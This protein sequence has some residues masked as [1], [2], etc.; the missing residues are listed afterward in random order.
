MN[1]IIVAVSILSLAFFSCSTLD[2]E[3]DFSFTHEVDVV[4]DEN[5]YFSSDLIDLADKV[6]VIDEYGDNIKEI[7]IQKIEVRVTRNDGQPEQEIVEARIEVAKADGSEPIIVSSLT[8]VTLSSLMDSP[9]TLELDEDGLASL[10]RLIKNA[11]HTLRI[12]LVGQIDQ[13][14]VDFTAQ[15]DFEGRLVANPL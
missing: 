4:S 5:T 3:R 14:P 6:D 13:A 11:P 12:V 7:D 8:G 2:V 15:F 1:K 9:E 10:N